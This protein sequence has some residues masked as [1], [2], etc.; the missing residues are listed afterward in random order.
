MSLVLGIAFALG[1]AVV[2]A[3]FA[4]VAAQ[5]ISE[6]KLAGLTVALAIAA[7][8]AGVVAG[9]GVVEDNI[10]ADVALLAAGGLAAAAA[11]E[12]GL[13]G[14]ARGLRRIGELERLRM[15]AR[16]DVAAAIEAEKRER[17]SE[18]ERL[19][20]RERANAGHQLGEQERQLAEERRDLVARQAERARAELTEAVA[21]AQERLERRLM[22]WAADLDRGQRE[23]EAKLGELAE[24]Q[25]QAVVA[26][27]ARLEADSERLTVA[28]EEHRAAVLALRN[29]LER[30][31]AEFLEEGRS[32][33][34]IHAAERRKALHEVGE[35]LRARERAL[36]EQIDRE[37]AEARARIAAGLTEAERRH[38]AQLDRA[39]E[40][41][42]N[43][44]SEDA[45]KRFDAQLKQSREQAA[46]R[47]ARELEKGIEQFARQAEK[48][49][50][51]RITEL[52]RTT[53]DR[54]QRRVA[55]VTRTA[56]AQQQ[57]AAERLRQISDRLD[58]ALGV[59][60]DRAASVEA[61][62]ARSSTRIE[63]G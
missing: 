41:A 58:D 56:E 30:L 36:R 13:L 22:A 17:V 42:A 26:Y 18:F 27:E 40:R 37:E 28:S 33:I 34:E 23:L 25:R 38:L 61:D 19:L 57:I 7:V 3:S 5:R 9:F 44:L 21:T 15:D 46:E 62:L 52:A 43:R 51:E 4:G 12:G 1:L 16:A 32:E 24:R 10:R 2:A 48:D 60:E 47:L 8:A 63:D 29:E 6:R 35:R 14:L 11:A 49:V 50:S 31:G 20:A 39:L 54:L 59:A 45:E 55:E 53:S